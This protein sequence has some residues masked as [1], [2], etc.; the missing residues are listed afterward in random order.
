MLMMGESIRQKWVNQRAHSK[1]FL[2]YFTNLVTL[3]FIVL[4][5]K[6]ISFYAKEFL[7]WIKFA[8]NIDLY[9][10]S[11]YYLLFILKF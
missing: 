8:L 9:H 1:V 4:T 7:K 2:V 6:H 5:P 10:A 3:L 11:L